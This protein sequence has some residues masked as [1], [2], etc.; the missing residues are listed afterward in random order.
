MIV[1]SLSRD[2]LRWYVVK[3]SRSRGYCAL[4]LGE[5]EMGGIGNLLAGENATRKGKVRCSKRRRT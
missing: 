5:E 4:T 2:E 3:L 1:E